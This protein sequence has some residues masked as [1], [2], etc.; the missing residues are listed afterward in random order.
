M[1]TSEFT[2]LAQAVLDAY[3]G[4]VLVFAPDGKLLYANAAGRRVLADLGVEVAEAGAVLPK[5]GRRGARIAPLWSNGR[6]LGEAVFLPESG[7]QEGGSTLADRERDAI[8]QTLEATGWKLTETA[9]RLGI[10]RT[11]LWRRLKAYGLSRNSRG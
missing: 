8:I 3:G 5:L 10:S 1:T 9:K 4:A 6:K 11:T 7:E 2:P